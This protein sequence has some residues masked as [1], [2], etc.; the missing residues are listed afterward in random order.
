MRKDK[1]RHNWTNADDESSFEHGW[2]IFAR[3]DNGVLEL[4]ALDDPYGVASDRGKQYAG[5][6]FGGDGRDGRAASYVQQQADAGDPTARRAIEEI[7]FHKSPD[8]SHFGL[9]KTWE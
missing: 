8:V 7:I 6:D 2:G 3:S 5:P 1:Q 4:H 9:K